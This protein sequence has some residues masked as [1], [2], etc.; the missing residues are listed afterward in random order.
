MRVLDFSSV[1]AAHAPGGL[2][3]LPADTAA[4]LGAFDGMH[5]GHQG[6]IARARALGSEVAVVTFEPRPAEVLAPQAGGRTVPPRLQTPGQ[7][8]HVC[9]ELGVDTLVILRF[10][11]GVSRL[12][13]EEFVEQFLLQGLRPAAVVVGYDFRFGAKRAG[14][15]ALLRT[16]LAPAGIEVSVVE[17]IEAAS[18][19]LAG[20]KL[21]STAIRELVAEGEV[22]LAAN[23]LGRLY[24]VAGKVEHGAARGRVL[25]YPTANV[26]SSS[27]HPKRGV[28]ACFLSLLEADESHEV[29]CWPAVANLGTNP[30][31]SATDPASPQMLEV[32]AL[33]VDLGD[34]L[35]G[36]AVEVAF[37]ARLRD[38]LR[39]PSVEALRTAIATDI[40]RAR[41]LLTPAAAARRH[42]TRVEPEP[43]GAALEQ[44]G[45]ER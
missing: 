9:R 14:D 45:G 11:L 12:S 29:Q 23:L 13:P 7:R 40:E 21:G 34:S 8:E 25:G 38:E 37:V 30:T 16:L 2:S 18:G 24:A 36:R 17:K 28:Y 42:A 27:L 32:H 20:E 4:C 15:P 5:R 19:P 1:P 10:D 3:P 26:A 41:P 6:L 33:D 44:A 43:V 39:F 22:A 31:F 35:Y